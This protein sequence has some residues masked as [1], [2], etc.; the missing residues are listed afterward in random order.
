MLFRSE[1]EGQSKAGEWTS[2]KDARLNQLVRYA[3]ARN[4]WIRFYTL[5]GATKSEL[6]CNGWFA[7]YN[8]GS[9]EAVRKRWVAATKAGADYIATDQYE[10]LGILLKSLK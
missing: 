7:S 6:S 4:L 10:D 9:R 8:F 1:P 3:H 2:E 5:D